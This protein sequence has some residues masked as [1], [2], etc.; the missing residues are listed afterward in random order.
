MR[1][2]A[3]VALAIRV[4]RKRGQAIENKQFCEMIHF[5]PPM[6]SMGYDQRRETA[7]FARRMN[8]FAFAGFSA[9]SRLKTQGSEIN[10]GF[11][12]ARRTLRRSATRKCHRQTVGIAKN[13]LGDDATRLQPLGGRIDQAASDSKAKTPGVDLRVTL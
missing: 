3:G 2:G 11:G 4:K 9:S 7:R 6:I 12:G 5:A 1:A 13:G 8:P 10:G